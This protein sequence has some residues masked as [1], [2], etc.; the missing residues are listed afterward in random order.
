MVN[1]SRGVLCAWKKDESLK[2]KAES[3]ALALEE[4]AGAAG[5][6]TKAASEELLAAVEARSA[7]TASGEPRLGL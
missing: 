6:A 4:I 1:S 2:E 3:G 7:K 5:R